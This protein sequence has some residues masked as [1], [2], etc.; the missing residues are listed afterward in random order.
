MFRKI[1]TIFVFLALAFLFSVT[2]V[3]AFTIVISPLSKPVPEY[4][5]TLNKDNSITLYETRD[6][7]QVTT[8]SDSL[9]YY[10][11]KLQE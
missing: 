5:L 4:H 2:I 9:S 10:I 8:T 3:T 7:Q 11:D 6:K 1:T